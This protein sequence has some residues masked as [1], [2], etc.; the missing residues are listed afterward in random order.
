MASVIMPSDVG[1]AASS[2]HPISDET[3]IAFSSEVGAGSR[4]ENG[5]KHQ[6]T[7]KSPASHRIVSGAAPGGGQRSQQGFGKTGLFVRAQEAP[8]GHPVAPG[9]EVEVFHAVFVIRFLIE[10]DPERIEDPFHDMA[11][12]IDPA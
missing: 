4:Q 12:M 9:G 2:N 7:G 1:R 5:S 3:W 10:P 6:V 11:T 8:D